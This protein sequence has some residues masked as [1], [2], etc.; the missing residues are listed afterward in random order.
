MFC[1]LIL[2]L[3]GDQARRHSRVLA[4]DHPRR[5]RHLHT[6]N[7]QHDYTSGQHIR[8]TYWAT[9]TQPACHV[10]IS[11]ALTSVNPHNQHTFATNTTLMF[12]FAL[13]HGSQH[14]HT[15][16]THGASQ[17]VASLCAQGSQQIHTAN[18]HSCHTY[19]TRMFMVSLCAAQSTN[20]RHTTNTH[21]HHT[22]HSPHVSCSCYHQW[23]CSHSRQ[24]NHTTNTHLP[25]THTTP[26]LSWYHCALTQP[27]THPHKPTAYWPHT[28][29][30]SCSCV[31]FSSS[32]ACALTLMYY[33]PLRG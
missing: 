7:Q 17:P 3:T 28:T 4:A 33:A 11:G 26:L 22:P 21:I 6:S 30:P 31:M 23:L 16:T 29:Q 32:L 10:L 15:T 1:S 5:H 8:H 18:T 2:L 19:T 13:S 27:P 9:H 20:H 24:H 14:I 12:S 25:D